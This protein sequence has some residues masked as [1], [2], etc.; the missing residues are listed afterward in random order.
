MTNLVRTTPA[1]AVTFTSFELI[2]RALREWASAD[3]GAEEQQRR[4]PA[5]A[6]ADARRE[7]EGAKQQR[8]Q[9]Q[10]DEPR[11]QHVGLASALQAP[12][13]AASASVDLQRLDAHTHDFEHK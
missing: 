5:A 8:Q 13:A 4:L 10:Q 9:Q 6:A 12:F 7:E 2:N 11:Q 1:A 3:S